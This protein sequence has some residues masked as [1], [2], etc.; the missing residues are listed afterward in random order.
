MNTLKGTGELGDKKKKTSFF[1]LSFL[2]QKLSVTTAIR[3]LFTYLF[4][5]CVGII[6]N[7]IGRN[8]TL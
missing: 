3:C 6:K 8:R 4:L 1:C 7:E 2:S 5:S